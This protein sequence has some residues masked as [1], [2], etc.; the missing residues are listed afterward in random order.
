MCVRSEGTCALTVC[1]CT[2]HTLTL[3]LHSTGAVAMVI[4][5]HTSII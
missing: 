1:V 2:C 5:F 4:H 3:F